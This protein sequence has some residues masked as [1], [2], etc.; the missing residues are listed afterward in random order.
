M[1]SPRLFWAKNFAQ[2]RD[3]GSPMDVLDVRANVRNKKTKMSDIRMYVPEQRVDEV[4]LN[5]LDVV[6]VRQDLDERTVLH[7]R[8]PQ[9]RHRVAW[10]PRANTNRTVSDGLKWAQQQQQPVL[11]VERSLRG[12]TAVAKRAP[13]PL[14]RLLYGFLP[15]PPS[16]PPKPTAT[17]KR[18]T[19]TPHCTRVAR[20]DDQ[21]PIRSTL[22]HVMFHESELQKYRHSRQLQ[23]TRREQR[24]QE[25]LL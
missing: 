21:R 25:V 2:L 17:R 8:S 1:L 13:V 5:A 15:P 10:P 6:L 3:H 18:R 4:T 16:P 24:R 14:S 7:G 23:R 19:R 11:H 20:E 22:R 9:H 12:D